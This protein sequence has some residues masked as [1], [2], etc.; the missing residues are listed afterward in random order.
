MPFQ[1]FEAGLRAGLLKQRPNPLTEGFAALAGGLGQ[2]AV[3]K[4]SEE[5]FK[6]QIK[7]QKIAEFAQQGIYPTKD[8]L[9]SLKSFGYDE[10]KLP[11][12][13]PPGFEKGETFVSL[14]AI[15]KQLE[16]ER[17]A[18]DLA[19][20]RREEHEA[21]KLS[22]VSPAGVSPEGVPLVTEMPQTKPF[23]PFERAATLR[24]LREIP[25]RSFQKDRF[26]FM[27]GKMGEITVQ[28]G[29]SLTSTEAE[30][31]RR[32]Q[33]D[34][35]AAAGKIGTRFE[36]DGTLVFEYPRYMDSR[37]SALL[38]RQLADAKK[39]LPIHKELLTQAIKDA[40]NLGT[41]QVVRKQAEA[42]IQ[43][44]MNMYQKQ[45]PVRLEVKEE[46]GA[47]TPSDVDIDPLIKE[48]LERQKDI[49]EGR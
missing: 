42:T 32:I 36:Q 4:L 22:L 49:N 16:F 46:I 39:M 23:L 25:I 45:Q 1:A 30:T 44:L 7:Q 33:K 19:K 8:I 20:Q 48:M 34:V 26:P 17:I 15:Q 6:D 38:A 9:P 41:S 2:L 27:V 37:T 21:F 35:Q 40:S 31:I 10:T 43:Q 5:L 24:E 13:S 12:F 3:K 29:E 47:G 28:P 18:G 14:P 11:T